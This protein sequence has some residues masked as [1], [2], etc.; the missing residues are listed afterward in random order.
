MSKSKVIVKPRS[1]LGKILDHDML[2]FAETLLL[3]I[4]NSTYLQPDLDS[5]IPV[6]SIKTL[7]CLDLPNPKRQKY[8]NTLL[9]GGRLLFNVIMFSSFLAFTPTKRT[10]VPCR[11][12]SATFVSRARS[13]L[14]ASPSSRSPNFILT[15]TPAPLTRKSLLGNLNLNICAASFLSQT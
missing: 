5:P 12:Y 14:S 4:E 2:G 6:Q 3:T 10:F 1:E 13:T 8:T 9:L 11:R 15:R 7:N